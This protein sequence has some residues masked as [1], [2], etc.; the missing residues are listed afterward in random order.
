MVLGNHEGV[1]TIIPPLARSSF[2]QK[3]VENRNDQPTTIA[4]TS[5]F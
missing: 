2:S 1:R 5:R 3:S 4:T